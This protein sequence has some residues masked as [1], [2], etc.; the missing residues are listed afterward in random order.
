M[1]PEGVKAVAELGVSR[2][3]VPGS[4]AR[5]IGPEF[6]RK[7]HTILTAEDGNMLIE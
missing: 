7:L 4:R 3:A 6:A 5:R 1:Q 2:S